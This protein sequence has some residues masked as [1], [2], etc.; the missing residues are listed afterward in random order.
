MSKDERVSTG[1]MLQAI[2]AL[3]EKAEESV[4]NDKETK[5]P[6]LESIVSKLTRKRAK[7]SN[8]KK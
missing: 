1:K 8:P 3:K 6:N 5:G 4:D 2:S 7:Q